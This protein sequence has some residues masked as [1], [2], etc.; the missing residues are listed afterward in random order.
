LATVTLLAAGVWLGA[1]ATPA[2]AA[3]TSCSTI[4]CYQYGGGSVTT[5]TN[6]GPLSV[7][8]QAPV[9]TILPLQ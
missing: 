8:L 5:W 1:L 9:W 2:S 3:T 4:F 7:T 6:I